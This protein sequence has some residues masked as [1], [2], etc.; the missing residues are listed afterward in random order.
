MLNISLNLNSNHS[1]SFNP[2]I[3]GV[4]D[5]IV[6]IARRIFHFLS[7]IF[8]CC[9]QWPESA[10]VVRPPLPQ[11]SA[12]QVASPPLLSIPQQPSAPQLAPPSEVLGS[13]IEGVRQS[14]SPLP[15]IRAGA[16]PFDAPVV[17]PAPVARKPVPNKTGTVAASEAVVVAASSPSSAGISSPTAPPALPSPLSSSS[18]SSS[19]S[20]SS[21]SGLDPARPAAP[22]A[23]I[24][25]PASPRSQEWIYDETYKGFS[26]QMFWM[27]QE[28]DGQIVVRGRS[29]HPD[30]P[31]LVEER[32]NREEVLTY[33]SYTMNDGTRRAFNVTKK[34]GETYRTMNRSSANPPTRW[35][36]MG[37]FVQWLPAQEER[38]DFSNAKHP[39]R[40]GACWIQDFSH[41]VIGLR[42][43]VKGATSSLN[44]YAFNFSNGN[45]ED[46][47]ATKQSAENEEA[48]I[49]TVTNSEIPGWSAKLIYEARDATLLSVEYVRPEVCCALGVL[50]LGKLSLYRARYSSDG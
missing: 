14:T 36:N 32:Y 37:K 29:S 7:S 5:P 22:S 41:P 50:D 18:Q 46:F 10:A 28:V 13:P 35:S 45:C 25:S 38:L 2:I 23:P 47:V 30:S 1:V 12:P 34:P 19:A 16:L 24:Q 48:I 4:I 21:N 20:I 15:M 42:N 43:F 49:V 3:R 39:E 40:V 33:Y 11:P 9:L 31:Y 27:R 26:Y 44:F 8:C 6:G 17:R